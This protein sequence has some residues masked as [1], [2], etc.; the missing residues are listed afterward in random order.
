MPSISV[1]NRHK[2]I[3]VCLLTLD[4]DFSHLIG[5]FMICLASSYHGRASTD[6]KLLY[7]V[8]KTWSYSTMAL[9]QTFSGH[10]YV[11]Q[12]NMQKLFLSKTTAIFDNGLRRFIRWIPAE[13]SRMS[14]SCRSHQV[15]VEGHHFGPDFRSIK[16][17]NNTAV[18]VTF[19]PWAIM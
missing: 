15:R 16:E 8:K 6:H 1:Q 18:H 11:V 17:L 10:K 12:K 19:M 3:F 4:W 13:T 14:T 7:D 9:S 2:L 5:A